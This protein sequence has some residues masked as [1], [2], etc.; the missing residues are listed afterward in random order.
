MKGTKLNIKNLIRINIGNTMI[1]AKEDHIHCRII[2][3]NSKK[4]Y[5]HKMTLSAINLL[6][7]SLKKK[8]IWVKNE[9]LEYFYFFLSFFKNNLIYIIYISYVKGLKSVNMSSFGRNIIK[10]PRMN[11]FSYSKLIFSRIKSLWSW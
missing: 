10:F 11:K 3:K 9:V 2:L 6:I 4:W 5:L 8:A 1:C 7:I